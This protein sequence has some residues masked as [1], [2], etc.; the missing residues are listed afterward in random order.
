MQV[1]V[2]DQTA[3]VSLGRGEGPTAG[4]DTGMG[5]VDLLSAPGRKNNAKYNSGTS[6]L[7]LV[8]QSV[9]QEERTTQPVCKHPV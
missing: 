5:C 6:Y 1:L 8:G 4:G 2:P 7:L 3:P 9:G